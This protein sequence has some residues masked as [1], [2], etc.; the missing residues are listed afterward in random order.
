M[1]A[2]SHTAMFSPRRLTI[3]SVERRL[4]CFPMQ[5]PAPHVDS[6][7]LGD[8]VGAVLAGT[9]EQLRELG[10]VQ[11]DVRADARQRDDLWIRLEHTRAGARRGT[12]LTHFS[13]RGLR[14]LALARCEP[15]CLERAASIL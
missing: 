2:D 3:S 15:A 13:N 4:Y 10:A 14:Q 7:V 5:Q 1:E 9:A 8:L 11:F 12:D 6:A